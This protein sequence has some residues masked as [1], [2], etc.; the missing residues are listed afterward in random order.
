[1][2]G[3]LGTNPHLPGTTGILGNCTALSNSG[4]PWRSSGGI[5]LFCLSLPRGGNYH[6]QNWWRMTW[7][8]SKCQ[9]FCMI[10]RK[11][12]KKKNVS[13]CHFGCKC[14]FWNCS[15]FASACTCSLFMIPGVAF[16]MA[17]HLYFIVIVALSVW[18]LV[19]SG[20]HALCGVCHD[21]S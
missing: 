19:E 17:L 9:L 16:W 20:E 15:H 8:Q 7:T 12:R 21:A 11:S 5:L 4:R 18:C 10:W 13:W 2:T 14:Y 6:W 3:G 1:M